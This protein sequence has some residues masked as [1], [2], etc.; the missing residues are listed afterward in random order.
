M[1]IVGN[2]FRLHIKTITLLSDG[3]FWSNEIV[4][5]EECSEGH[6]LTFSYENVSDMKFQLNFREVCVKRAGSYGRVSVVESKT[7]EKP[8]AIKY[9][10][11]QGKL[12]IILK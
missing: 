1:T 6:V 12:L 9:V 11:V 3:Q 5:N 10:K 7:D 8:F 2:D 4:V